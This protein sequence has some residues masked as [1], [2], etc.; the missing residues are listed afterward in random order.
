MDIMKRY[1]ASI[2]LISF[3]CLHG[4][5]WR[6]YQEHNVHFLLNK[7]NFDVAR[8]KL[9]DLF[10]A[11][12][13]SAKLN[14]FEGLLCYGK[15]NFEGAIDFFNRAVEESKKILDSAVLDKAYT[16][17]GNSYAH[18]M[19]LQE[20]LD[21]YEKACSFNPNNKQA[22][23]NAEKIKKYLQEQ[24]KQQEQQKENRDKQ[25][26]N[27]ANRDQNK[28]TN[29]DGQSS[30]QQSKDMKQDGDARDQNKGQQDQSEKKQQRSDQ[31]SSHEQPPQQSEQQNQQQKNNQQEQN[32]S[33][34]T[35]QPQGQQD[36]CSQ[37]K[38]NTK[39]CQKIEKGFD[40]KEDSEHERYLQKVLEQMNKEDEFG[41]KCFIQVHVK[42]DSKEQHGQK[43]W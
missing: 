25:Q 6:E 13:D 21:A 41:N 7:K 35:P 20:A 16:N 32:F 8:N 27:D 24:P 14:L 33:D 31:N 19:K 42:Q 2:F 43:N 9:D 18:Q 1:C 15:E 38:T 3:F 12:P 30:D 34:Q 5:W 22:R 26:N 40:G 10:V 37:G 28:Q 11:N 4:S 29:S 36:S 23:E 17:L 39:G